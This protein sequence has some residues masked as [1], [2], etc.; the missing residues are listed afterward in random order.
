V[1]DIEGLDF[2]ANNRQ[3]L[4]RH[5]LDDAAV[6]DILLDE[7]KFFRQVQ[8]DGRSGSHLMIG[9]SSAGRHWTI[10]IVK[11]DDSAGIWRPI[12]GWPSTRREIATWQGS[13]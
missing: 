7:P 9:T 6:W 2:D 12:T 1:D 13:S 8:R 3:H 5:G 4:E 11:L 10:V